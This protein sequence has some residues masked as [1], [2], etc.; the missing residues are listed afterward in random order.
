MKK[1]SV[2]VPLDGST[3]SRQVLSL[4]QNYFRPEDVTLT[5]L[6]VAKPSA[7]T[8]EFTGNNDLMSEQLFLSTHGTYTARME[9][10]WAQSA[11]VLETQRKELQTTLQKEAER[12]E[13]KGYQVQYEV[14]FGEPAQRII[15]YVQ[16]MNMDLIAM[17]SH[18]RTGIGRLV[19]GSVAE[20]VLRGVHIP[21]LLWRNTEKTPST[22]VAAKTLADKLTKQQPLRIATATDGSTFAQNATN[23]AHDLAK[24]MG[25]ELTVLVVADE[26]EA[27]AH[28]QERTQT[29]A[30][31]LLDMGERA[32]VVPLVGYPDEV[33]LNYIGNEPID[34]LVIGAF[35]DRGAGATAAIGATAQRLLQH[36][37]TSVMLTK[38]AAPQ[39]RRI[40]V[41][42][43]LDDE[44]VVTVAAEIA[45]QL[46]AQLDVIHVL[47][48]QTAAYLNQPDKS[49]I[50]I[51]PLL[52]QNT[53]LSSVI[54]HWITL[55]TNQGFSEE[56]LHL[57]QGEAL[58]TI[59]ET[60]RAEAYDLV[61]VG[62]QSGAG[63]FLGSVASGV[64]QFA[65][66]SVLIVRTKPV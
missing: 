52:A 39:F 31:A 16:D 50:T 65:N 66:Q 44:T 6:H 8:T 32:Q 15:D 42:A 23:I 27:I 11:Q 59:L 21:V 3:F 12:L 24:T 22:T 28:S 34:L 54:R 1:Q 37:P 36:A 10:G 26:H 46:N 9:T 43:A 62:S 48:P 18:G 35:D 14:H 25:G 56:H 49:E 61:I 41:A 60:S 47:P 4:V 19:L 51:A 53:R 38:G 33:V 58:H 20:R 2:L 29:M 57:F 64:A 5:L 63:H 45:K 17:A 7:V 13:A 55:L 40:L 30:N